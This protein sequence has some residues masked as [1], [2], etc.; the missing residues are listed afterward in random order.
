[1]KDLHHYLKKYWLFALASLTIALISIIPLRLAIASYQA[2]DPQAILVLGGPPERE[3]FAAYIAQHYPHLEIWVSTGTPPDI[4][5]P[6]FQT[7]EISNDR[8]HL[9]YTAVDTVTNFTS[10][11][12]EFKQR[13]IKHLYVITSDYHMARSKVIATL[14]LGSQGI[15][16]TPL[17]VPGRQPRD[18]LARILRDGGRSLLWIITGRTGASLNPHLPASFPIRKCS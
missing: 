7:A 1:V 10:L 14:I 11:I 5:C 4:V 2:P 8:L 6:I 16:F 9:D 13:G 17:S 18:S 15:T 3:K 12:P